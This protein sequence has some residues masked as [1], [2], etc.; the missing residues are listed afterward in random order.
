MAAGRCLSSKM[1]TSCSLGILFLGLG[2]CFLPLAHPLK[3]PI[4]VKDLL[5]ALPRQVSWPLLN[6]LHSAVDLLPRF[7][8]TVAPDNGTVGWKG[9]CFSDSEARLEF[10]GGESGYDLGGGVLHLKVHAFLFF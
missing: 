1:R 9:A 8:G 10:R 3:V 7:V 2:F 4:R 5:P 6:N